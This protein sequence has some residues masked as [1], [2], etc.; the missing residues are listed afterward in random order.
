[1]KNKHI[2]LKTQ[3]EMAENLPLIQKQATT[4]NEYGINVR[5]IGNVEDIPV[6]CVEL[7]K[8]LAL[9]YPVVSCNCTEMGFYYSFGLTHY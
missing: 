8:L 7:N 2:N 1:M 5:E 3:R 6:Y 9:V 4:L